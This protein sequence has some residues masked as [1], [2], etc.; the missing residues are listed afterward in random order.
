MARTINYWYQQIL[1]QKNGTPELDDLDS[2]SKVSDFNLWAYIVAFVIC[3]LDNLFDLHRSGIDTAITTLKPH[4]LQWYQALALR[5]QYGQNTIADSDQY[6]NTGLTAGQIA[7][8]KIIVQAAVTEIAGSLRVKVVKLVS[9]DYAQLTE[10]ELEAFDAY[11]AKQKDAGVRI[12]NQSLPPD[13]LKLTLDIFYDALILNS[14]GSR[15]DGGAPTPVPDAITTYLKNLKFNGEYANTR[16]TD[17]LQLVDGVVLPVIKLS[18]AQYGAFAYTNIDEV[19]IPDGGYLRI[20]E[21]GLTINY[22][23]YVQY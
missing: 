17:Q 11:M 22:R 7:A 15:I 16:L 19:Y 8:Q 23:P 9:D 5:F 20:P 6:A 3:A 12:I 13:G 18:Q 2:V 21:G 10:P 1:T 14:D 4:G